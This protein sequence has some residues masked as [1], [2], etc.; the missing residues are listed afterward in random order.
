MTDAETAAGMRTLA[1]TL[2]SDAE[3]LNRDIANFVTEV[4]AA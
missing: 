1:V 2:R 4:S 3:G